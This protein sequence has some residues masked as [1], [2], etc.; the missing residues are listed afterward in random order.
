MRTKYRQIIAL[1]LA[2][3]FPALLLAAEPEAKTAR[4]VVEVFQ[5]HLLEAMKSGKRIGYAGRYEKLFNPV[6]QSHDL[7]KI[8]R[9]IVGREWE[10]LTKDQQHTFV[11]VLIRLSVSSYAHNFRDYNGESFVFESL[12]E[13]GKG[14]V[15]VRSLFKIPNDKDVKFDYMLKQNGDTW[16]IINIIA[17]GVSDLALRRTE[18]TSVLQREG[19]DALIKRLNEKIDNHSKM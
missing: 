12:E 13:T 4:Q 17:N 11:D 15:V 14:G 8:A 5:G 3:L 1:V 16:R 19:F 18:Y 10:K 9:I 2:A 6:A 7:E